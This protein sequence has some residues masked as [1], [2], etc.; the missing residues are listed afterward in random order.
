MLD[1]FN[2][3]GPIKW[4]ILFC[5]L[6]ALIA[7]VERALHLH[8]ARIRTEDF[9]RGILNVLKRGN[10]DEAL[11]IC[12]DTPGP[13]AYIVKTAILH[14]ADDR[15]SIRAAIDD[16]GLSEISRLERRLVVIATVAQ[17]APVLGLLGTVL[18]MV[19]A[20][21]VMKVQA[22]L[23][24]QVDIYDML[25]QALVTTG[26]GLTVAIPAHAA[27]NLLVY[28]IEGIVLDMERTASEIVAFL[29]ETHGETRE[30]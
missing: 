26:L 12:E 8:R 10:H 9:L 21:T 15:Y 4:I 23:V 14:R 16:I 24:Q 13:V 19:Q 20:F 25:I 11:S 1:M 3:A 27:Y 7:F 30:P 2:T 28:K 18:A 22:P 17:I 6:A 5:G 29:K